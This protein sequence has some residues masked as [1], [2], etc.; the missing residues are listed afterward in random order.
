MGLE[1]RLIDSTL[2][3]SFSRFTTLEEIDETLRVLK[4]VIPMLQAVARRA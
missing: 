1:P 2:R 4:E 3:F